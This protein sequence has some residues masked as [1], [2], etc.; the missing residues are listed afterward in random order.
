MVEDKKLEQG[1]ALTAHLVSTIGSNLSF[2]P[3]ALIIS[4]VFETS[5]GKGV[6]AAF[7]LK[8]LPG[9]LGARWFSTICNRAGYA[10]SFGVSQLI[11]GFLQLSSALLLITSDGMEKTAL[12]G[13]A[14]SFFPAALVKSLG[15]GYLQDFDGKN[16]IKGVAFWSLIHYLGHSVATAA[17]GFLSGTFDP[18]YVF[19]VDGVSFLIS[20]FL[21]LRITAKKTKLST[22]SNKPIPTRFEI[23]SVWNTYA[24]ANLIRSVGYGLINPLL[25][26]KLDSGGN[27][28]TLGSLYLVLGTSASFGAYIASRT[29]MTSTVV[30]LLTVIESALL[31]ALFSLHLENWVFLIG[32]AVTAI[33]MVPIEVSLAT[34]HQS[35]YPQSSSAAAAVF[36][37]SEA[38]GFLAGFILYLF[39]SERH[40]DMLSASAI[41]LLISSLVPLRL[42][43]R[44][45]QD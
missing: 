29:K 40:I 10:R 2:L 5:I 11:A 9:V 41:I 24:T 43:G 42:G 27:A 23:R 4:S 34:R 36:S 16:L 15:V 44:H 32:A 12:V 37:S 38:A 21:W 7:V 3:M 45:D 1:A 19:I 14:V 17:G 39:V 13:L 35:K 8:M 25:P 22:A 31:L 18:A 20:G 30:A 33:A 26:Q 6:S 28:I